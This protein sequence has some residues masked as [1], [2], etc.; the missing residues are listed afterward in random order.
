MYAYIFV[1]FSVSE[2]GENGLGDEGADGGNAP[3][4][5][6]WARTAPAERQQVRM[7]PLFIMEGLSLTS[8]AEPVQVVLWTCVC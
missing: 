2:N 8:F 4:I 6:F 1:F 5:N 3:I 7:R